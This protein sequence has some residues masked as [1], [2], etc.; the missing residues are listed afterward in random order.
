MGADEET[1]EEIRIAIR[2]AYADGRSIPETTIF[3]PSTYTSTKAVYKATDYASH[4][5]IPLSSLLFSFPLL[6]FSLLT[7]SRRQFCCIWSALSSSARPLV[8]GDV[9]HL[10]YK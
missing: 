7:L 3:I 2:L 6:V 10:S 9:V 1:E 4:S 8:D 5:L